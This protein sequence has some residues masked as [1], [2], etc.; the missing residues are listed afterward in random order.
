MTILFN[1]EQNLPVQKDKDD[2]IDI[3]LFRHLTLHKMVKYFNTLSVLTVKGEN[4]TVGLQEDGKLKYSHPVDTSTIILRHLQKGLYKKQ[5]IIR[6]SIIA[7]NKFSFSRVYWD[8]AS[9]KD[10][11]LAEMCRDGSYYSSKP[12]LLTDD[13]P[14]LVILTH[15]IDPRYI[16]ENFSDPVPII[17]GARAVGATEENAEHFIVTSM[18]TILKRNV[19]Y[20]SKKGLTLVDEI[21]TRF[22]SESKKL[23]DLYE[24][25]YKSLQPPKKSN[26]HDVTKM[27]LQHIK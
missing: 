17:H 26:P 20:A 24:L 10:Q 1:E 4:L 3:P 8:G 15:L 12:T 5:E 23:T 19:Y 6:R 22:D 16:M 11:P 2:R 18:P 13:E 14:C 7:D 9:V 25:N 21:K 27:C